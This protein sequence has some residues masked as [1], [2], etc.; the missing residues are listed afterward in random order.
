M[1]DTLVPIALFTMITVIFSLLFYFR[2][3]SRQDVQQTVRMAMESGQQ[4]T[5]ELLETLSDAIGSKFGDLRRGL[6][7]IAIAIGFVALSQAVADEEAGPAMLG[8][9]AFP[10]AIGVAYVGL[11]YFT[12]KR[13]GDS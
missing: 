10:F 4:L 7:S 9:A 11:W 2:Y 12:R 13:S 3:R 1:E 6:I 5:P 8:I